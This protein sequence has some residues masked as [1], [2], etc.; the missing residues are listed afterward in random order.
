MENGKQATGFLCEQMG[1]EDAEDITHFGGW[2]AFLQS[3]SLNQQ[4][5]KELRNATS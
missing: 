3:L 4:P 1:I 5:N 2:R